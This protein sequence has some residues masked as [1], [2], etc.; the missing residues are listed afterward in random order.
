MPNPFKL[1]KQRDTQFYGTSE[2]AA[3]DLAHDALTQYKR[4]EEDIEKWQN[5]ILQD[6]SLP[7]WYKFTLF[8]E[9]YFLVAGG[10]IWIGILAFAIFKYEEKSRDQVKELE[11]TEVKVTE[12]KVSRRQGADAGR[13]T[14]STYDVE[15][16][17]DSASDVDCMVDGVDEKHRGDLSQESDAS[18]TLAMMDQQYDRDDVGRFLYLEVWFKFS[19]RVIQKV[20]D[21]TLVYESKP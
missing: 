7:E 1:A 21:S 19:A 18:V 5:P 9:P 11:N 15:Y 8:S 12:A 20:K 10:T 13:T 14:D 17:T 4:W 2:R 16:T 6:E 3:K